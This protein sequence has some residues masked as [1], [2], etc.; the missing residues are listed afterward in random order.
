M[1]YGLSSEEIDWIREGYRMFREGDPAFMDRY[2]PDARFE[3]P[4]S[5][6]GGGTYHGP[7]DALEF[8]TTIG[9]LFDSPY[10]DPE[11]FLRAGDRLVVFGTWRARSRQSGEEIAARFVHDLRLSSDQGPLMDLKAVSFE[12]FFDTAA[13]LGSLG[14]S[15]PA[16]G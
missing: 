13:I 9:E 15:G 7:F 2:A 6:P 1:P 10:A 3:F 16:A 11:D 14:D 8:W 5:M 4:A 12:V